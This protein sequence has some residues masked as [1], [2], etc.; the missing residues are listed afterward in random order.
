[1]AAAQ[2]GGTGGS[3]PE[4]WLTLDRLLP[5]SV[6]EVSAVD[7]YAWPDRPWLRANMVASID[8]AATLDGRV[9]TL[10]GP[11]DQRLLLL[12]RAT[13]DALV[14]GAGTL[15]T[16]GYGPLTVDPALAA[17]RVAS[18]Q[19]EAPR[20]VV[21]TRSLAVD[22]DGAAFTEALEPPLL[23]APTAAPAERVAAARAVAEVV[24][25]G[26]AEVDLAGM[27][28]HL[29]ARGYHRVLSEGGPSLLGRLADEGLLDELCLAVAPVLAGGGA[30][31]V[32]AGRSLRGPRAMILEQVTERDGYL[33]LRYT[34]PDSTAAT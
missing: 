29:N 6:S 2:T 23:F 19:S 8:G 30:S 16:E 21:V 11:A 18:G 7:S 32:T 5:A 24:Q 31:G 33:F 15:R 3:T 10:T 25:L 20:L 27:V 1:M 12:L 4:G 17:L 9:G 26:D 22:L 28:A 34:N 13:A 14:V